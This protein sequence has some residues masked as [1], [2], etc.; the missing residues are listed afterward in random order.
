M[1]AAC[2]ADNRDWAIMREHGWTQY[3][4][5]AD[6]RRPPKV[7]GHKELCFML[8]QFKVKHKWK[9]PQ[10]LRS[11]LHHLYSDP[12]PGTNT[13]DFKP[14]HVPFVN[15]TAEAAETYDLKDECLESTG[16]TKARFEKGR[17][18]RRAWVE[19]MNAERSLL[20]NKD[21]ANLTAM[22]IKA[23]SSNAVRR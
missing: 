18:E 13:N 7:P 8:S 3:A 10:F 22:V 14:Q 11:I 2:S 21:M 16:V 23:D 15:P 20:K 6:H 1:L 5:F 12:V 4:G 19:A 17:I 9:R